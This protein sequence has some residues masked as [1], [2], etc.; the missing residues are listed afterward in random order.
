M[1]DHVHPGDTHSLDAIADAV[2]KAEPAD[3][4]KQTAIARTE[5]PGEDEWI[6]LIDF[7]CSRRKLA[8]MS[9]EAIL[10]LQ[11]TAELPGFHG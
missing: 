2:D 1:S 11:S 8:P 5:F 9:D 10:E 3:G 6:A 4:S 7:V